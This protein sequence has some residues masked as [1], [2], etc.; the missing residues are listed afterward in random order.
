MLERADISKHELATE[1]CR[2][3]PTT[4]SRTAILERSG[5]SPAALTAG[6]T[7]L[8][9]QVEN[10][11]DVSMPNVQCLPASAKL[12]CSRVDED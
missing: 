6:R 3:A 10:T 7:M 9:G 5:P 1:S 8:W 4:Y 12:T 2:E 11:C